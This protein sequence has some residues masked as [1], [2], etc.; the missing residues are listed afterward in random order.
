MAGLCAP[1]FADTLTCAN[2]RL[3]A[4][5][6]RYT[7][8]VVD[9]HLLL[10]AGFDRRTRIQEYM[11]QSKSP[12]KSGTIRIHLGARRGDPAVV[13]PLRRQLLSAGSAA[14]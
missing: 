11:Q 13:P 3:G 14:P 6:D 7:S 1:R 2:A 4:D 10:F 5:A 9:L 12:M 8:T